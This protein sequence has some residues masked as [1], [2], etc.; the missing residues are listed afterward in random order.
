MEKGSN[1]PSLTS[2]NA[3]MNFLEIKERKKKRGREEGMEKGKW[4]KGG[5]TDFLWDAGPFRKLRVGQK[6]EIPRG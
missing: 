3:L 6:Q 4:R 1:R 5:M 2:A